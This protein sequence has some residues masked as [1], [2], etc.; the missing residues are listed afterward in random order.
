MID[1]Q[2][3]K[4]EDDDR[5]PRRSTRKISRCRKAWARSSDRTKEHVGTTDRAIIT[6]R[7]VLLEQLNVMEDGQHAA[8][9]RSG[10][11]PLLRAID[12]RVPKGQPWREATR[13]HATGAV[14]KQ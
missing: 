6:L 3:Q 8:R 10:E 4:T 1:R 5:H 9:R 11:L 2:L 7:Q 13:E 14:L 12:R